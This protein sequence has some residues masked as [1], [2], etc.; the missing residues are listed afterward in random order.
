MVVVATYG[1]P[2]EADLAKTLLESEGIASWEP[3]G[4]LPTL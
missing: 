1:Y 3:T 4:G 2:A